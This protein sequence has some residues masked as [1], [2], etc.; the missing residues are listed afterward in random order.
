MEASRLVLAL[1]VSGLAA[2]AF[3]Q[4]P[5][6]RESPA[7]DT[8]PVAAG[9]AVIRG[10][11][12]V[13]GALRQ[14]SGQA[15]R[16]LSR[17][18]VRA[19]SPAL[20]SVKAVLTDGSGRYEIS[21]LPAGR[22]TISFS[23]VSY[24]RASYGQRR[25]LGPGAPVDVASGRTMTL[26]DVALQR[27]GVITGRIVDE[28]GDPMAGVQVAPMRYSFT[29]GQRRMLQ[30]GP[31]GFTND[32]GEYRIHGLTPGRYYLSA[33]FRNYNDST[34][35][36]SAYVPTYYPGSSNVADAQ[37]LTIA[38][39]QTLASVNL[40]LVPTVASRVSGAAF[41]SRGR[42][43]DGAYVTLIDRSGGTTFGA[44]GG[45]V[46]PDGT[47]FV[48]GVTPGDYTL[49]AARPSAPDE[50]ATA[51]ISVSGGDVNDVQVV[52]VKPTT[53][54]GTV[55]FEAG[56]GKRPAATAVR[57]S[58]LR[59]DAVVPA[60]PSDSPKDDWTF[61]T[62]TNPGRA[63]IRAAVFGAADWRLKRVLS[64]DGAD[65][66]DDGLDVPAAASIEGLIVEFTTRLAELSGTVVDA[67][68]AQVRDCVV[69]LF[70]QDERRWAT[71]T[72]YF[73]VARP[74][75]NHTFRARLAAGDYYAAAFELDDPSVSLNDPDIFQQL[76]E[77]AARL[78]LGEA[79]KKTLKLTL[80]EPPVY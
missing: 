17:V 44:R 67:T 15:D 28:F 20:K 2:G 63:I 48:G 35:D 8:P 31:T 49:R 73:A 77:R 7:R 26:A 10:R 66:T 38:A 41:D 45:A 5:A 18:E 32:Q 43:F 79:E 42:P 69:V 29:N 16:P 56:G 9:T 12:I 22:Y 62:R 3:A 21:E 57:I 23:R 59:P 33:N 50:V 27:G 55:V 70:G 4:P 58:V 78:S 61:E 39:G 13:A 80:I 68:G 14:G 53:L 40:T 52:A 11:V 51:T 47:F 60:F 24:V 54:R 76:R 71:G 1:F 25:P 37:R 36:R 75:Q 19:A 64:A 72:R 6:P 46:R 30:T 65:I 34:G 74:D